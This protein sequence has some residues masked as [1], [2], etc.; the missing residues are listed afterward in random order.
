MNEISEYTI[1]SKMPIK[2][3]V[4]ANST[5][6]TICWAYNVK[7]LNGCSSCII[8]GNECQ[9]VYLSS[10]ANET[11]SERTY[12]GSIEWNGK[13]IGYKITQTPNII[14]EPFEEYEITSL[15]GFNE[16]YHYSASTI[17][18][19]HVEKKNIIYFY[20][21]SAY[22]DNCD[23]DP[24]ISSDSGETA[25]LFDCTQ[26]DKQ[27]VV[28]ALG[29]DIKYTFEC[30][31]CKG[32][33]C[34]PS[35]S[36][37]VTNIVLNPSSIKRCKTARGDVNTV[38]AQ[39][40]YVETIKNENCTVQ[41]G[42]T[43]LATYEID[44]SDIFVDENCCTNGYYVV[45]KTIGNNNIEIPIPLDADDGT[46][47]PKCNECQEEETICVI[48]NSI[49]YNGNTYSGKSSEGYIDVNETVPL[50]GGTFT[51]NYTMEISRKCSSGS[52]SI[53]STTFVI[54]DESNVCTTSSYTMSSSDGS[55]ETSCN[56]V[57]RKSFEVKIEPETE[58]VDFLGEVEFSPSYISISNDGDNSCEGGSVKFTAEKKEYGVTTPYCN[59]IR[60]T[61]KA[62][63]CKNKN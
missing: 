29:Q 14:S 27:G 15:S 42:E 33:K 21:T 8:G 40:E 31:P 35:T 17:D 43:Y 19:G 6:A 37:T 12:N 4:D 30:G 54:G 1:V 28:N 56:T 51:L 50:S 38:T 3:V 34:V 13:N 55:I 24:I 63:R 60:F 41:T 2:V 25:I 49:E 58:N 11:C 22:T 62:I 45:T 44:V 53:S 9:T 18:C 52:S 7:L 16:S 46:C 20:N 26:D 5:S 10:G 48:L 59:V 39:I 57:T 32:Q 47:C 61:Y 36:I 23:S